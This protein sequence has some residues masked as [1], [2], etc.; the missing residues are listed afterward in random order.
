MAE[1]RWY[2]ATSD[3]IITPGIDKRVCNGGAREFVD[4]SRYVCGVYHSVRDVDVVWAG[5]GCG[6]V[7]RRVYFVYAKVVEYAHNDTEELVE[8]AFW[9]VM[10]ITTNSTHVASAAMFIFAFEYTVKPL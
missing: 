9:S 3:P 8:R 7:L 1:T 5:K 10:M 4:A 6:R 2:V